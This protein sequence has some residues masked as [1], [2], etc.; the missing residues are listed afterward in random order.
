MN[1]Y[2]KAGDMNSGSLNSGPCQSGMSTVGLSTVGLSPDDHHFASDRTV[3]QH[4]QP[5]LHHKKKR[6]G[7]A[8]DSCRIKKTKCDGKKPCNKCVQDNKICV[9]T[10]KK[11]PKEKSYPN[12]YVE[13]LETRLDLLTKAF[14]RMIQLSRPHLLFLNDLMVTN[15]ESQDADSIHDLDLQEPKFENPDNYNENDSDNDSDFEAHGQFGASSARNEAGEVIIPINRVLTYLINNEGLLHNLPMEWENGA[16][17]A[18]SYSPA[19]Y[20]MACKQFANHK[21]NF[22]TS[23]RPLLNSENDS[24][25]PPKASKSLRSPTGTKPFASSSGAKYKP[26]RQSKRHKDSDQFKDQDP[27]PG[28]VSVKLEPG[29]DYDHGMDFND[30]FDDA[31]EMT[32]INLNNMSF[33]D[34]N[35]LNIDEFP[36]NNYSSG[37]FVLANS[38]TLNDG[39]SNDLSDLESDSNSIYSLSNPPITNHSPSSPTITGARPKISSTSKS[40]GGISLSDPNSNSNTNSQALNTPMDD[41]NSFRPPSLFSNDTAGSNI[42]SHKNGS[43]SSLTNRLEGHQLNASSP[44]NISPTST[45]DS[46]HTAKSSS[47]HQGPDDFSSLAQNP[48][49]VDS[50]PHPQLLRRSSS[51]VGRPRSPSQQKLKNIGHVHKPIHSSH[52]YGH[53]HNHSHSQ[54]PQNQSHSHLNSTGNSAILP[55]SSE[56][57]KLDIDLSLP[58]ESL[59]NSDLNFDDNILQDI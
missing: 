53:S 35:N 41:S 14:E 27:E 54:L 40:S 29:A 17:I 39:L 5:H 45:F 22:P 34:N 56:R 31:G 13:L 52:P 6:V 55:D 9:F 33:F 8:C 7:K 32:N 16:H 25:S 47:S 46:Q 51:I 26:R 57:A 3:L 49:L 59:P 38:A 20:E 48:S 42:F 36:I 19:H 30:E 2:L 58:S 44:G 37:G 12:G 43:V 11:K 15:G 23:E 10:E 1:G 28:Y 24:V 18:A 21:L 50:Q 4:L